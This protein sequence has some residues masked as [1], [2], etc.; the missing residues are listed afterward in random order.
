MV[1]IDAILHYSFLNVHTIEPQLHVWQ[2]NT[3]TL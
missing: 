3:D 1:Y 2:D